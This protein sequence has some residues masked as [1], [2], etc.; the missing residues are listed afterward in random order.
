MPATGDRIAVPFVDS[1][2]MGGGKMA[3]HWGV[4][5]GA[6]ITEQLGIAG[7]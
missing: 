5:D 6:A 1:F 4:T 7:P 2:R 3:E